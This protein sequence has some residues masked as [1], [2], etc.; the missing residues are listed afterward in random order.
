MRCT[1]CAACSTTLLSSASGSSFCGLLEGPYA[2]DVLRAYN[3]VVFTIIPELEP[4]F[5]FDQRNPFHRYDVWEHT[6]HALEAAPTDM[7]A[8]LRFALLLHDI[9]KPHCLTIDEE[10]KGH[11]M[12][13]R[14]W[15]SP[16]PQKF[17]AV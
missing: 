9:G 16:S 12:G 11:A 13:T 6:L 3:D 8:T 1:N 5:E 14:R 15:V 10:G 17:A 7:E 4:E 2:V